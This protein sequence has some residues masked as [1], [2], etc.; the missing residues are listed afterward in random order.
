MDKQCE[1][2]GDEYAPMILE[3]MGRGSRLLVSIEIISYAIFSIYAAASYYFIESNLVWACSLVVV[4]VLY[5]SLSKK[6]NYLCYSCQL[7]NKGNK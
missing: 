4:L 1:N 5:L 2:C 7:E 3:K 6:D